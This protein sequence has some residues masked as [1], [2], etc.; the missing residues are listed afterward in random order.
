MIKTLFQTE[1]AS[2]DARPLIAARGK[3][4]IRTALREQLGLRL[5]SRK[6]PLDI[7]GQSG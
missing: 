7:V 2:P 4:D 1:P 3:P 6:V 5:V